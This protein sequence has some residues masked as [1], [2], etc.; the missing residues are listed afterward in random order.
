MTPVMAGKK[1]DPLH[2]HRID[3]GRNMR[4]FYAL[5][6]QPTLFGG[7]SVIRHGRRIGTCGQSMMQTF[8]HHDDATTALGRLGRGKRRR[9]YRDAGGEAGG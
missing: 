9:G 5:S 2:L 1:A 3:P 7:A 4:R 6:L 8:D